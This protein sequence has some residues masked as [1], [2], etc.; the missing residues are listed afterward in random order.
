MLFPSESPAPRGAACWL[1]HRGQAAV[2]I[3]HA[4][5][6]DPRSVP[7][8]PGPRWSRMCPS[9]WQAPH[10]ML[11]ACTAES[12]DRPWAAS[13]VRLDGLSTRW[14]GWPGARVRPARSARRCA[15]RASTSRRAKMKVC[16]GTFFAGGRRPHQH[17]RCL[18]GRKGAQPAL[19]TADPGRAQAG[20]SRGRAE[21][22]DAHSAT[23]PHL[24][25]WLG[26]ACFIV[27]DV[28]ST[29]LVVGLLSYLPAS[30]RPAALRGQLRRLHRSSSLYAMPT[31]R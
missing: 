4:L 10:H 29:A 17:C 20:C 18:E 6:R 26:P 3:E 16:W 12:P 2:R 7:P 30:S 1:P 22:G 13:G 28:L 5:S 31:N 15:R 24:R 19:L 21:R 9:S 27:S 11:L 14:G 23:R 25:L 8:A